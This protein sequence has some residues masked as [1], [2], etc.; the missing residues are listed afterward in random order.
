[1]T[2]LPLL[3]LAFAATLASAD[4]AGSWRFNLVSFGEEIFQAKLDLKLDGPVET[5]LSPNGRW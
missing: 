3:V 4:I 5:K 2:K 1:M